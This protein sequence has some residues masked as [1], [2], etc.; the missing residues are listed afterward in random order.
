M[1]VV[2]YTSA[3]TG[4]CLV[5]SLPKCST[6]HFWE[7]RSMVLG[8][9]DS[10]FPSGL[11]YFWWMVDVKQQG[12][13]EGELIS[14]FPIRLCLLHYKT[15]AVAREHTEKEVSSMGIS[16]RVHESGTS[17]NRILKGVYYTPLWSH[18]MVCW[19]YILTPKSLF[20]FYISDSQSWQ[21][22]ENV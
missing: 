1:E 22:V 11:P 3:Q 15:G 2:K 8:W 20:P 7:M 5:M 19:I 21:M 4:V 9:P 6:T 17:P 13:P 16:W 10:S 18:P 14:Q 12:R